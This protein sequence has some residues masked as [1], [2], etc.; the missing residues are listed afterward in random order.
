MSG[1]NKMVGIALACLAA[2]VLFALFLPAS[3]LAV[4]L[5]AIIILMGF[6]IIKQ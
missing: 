4:I 5:A 6:C 2:G 3:I 1:K